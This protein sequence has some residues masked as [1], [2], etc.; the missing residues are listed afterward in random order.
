MKS[1]K[2]QIC[3]AVAL[4]LLGCGDKK[5]K[6]VSKPPVRVKTEIVSSQVC[7]SDQSYVG[8]VEENEATAVSFT[9]MGVIRKMYVD[10]GQYVR[11]GQLLA[12]MDNTTSES[13]LEITQVSTTQAHDMVDQAQATYDQAK[14][15]YERMKVM[16][17][18]GALPEIKW[19]EA[20]TSLRRA[21]T[22]LKTAQSGVT[23]AKATEKI[24][25][26][27][28]VD[29]RLYAPV[30]GI[31]GK[32]LLATGETALPSQAVV[33][34]LNI[35]NVKVKVPVPEME[36]RNI[37]TN[38]SSTISV[39]AAGVNVE[40]GSIEKGVQADALT[41]TYDVRVNVHN[42]GHALLPGMVANVRFG[43]YGDLSSLL[44]PITAVQKKG[45]GSLFVWTIADDN[46]AHRTAVSVGTTY[47]NRISVTGGITEGQRVVVEGYQ[48]LSEGT[49]VVYK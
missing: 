46:T 41:H 36:M 35:D 14:D 15:A 6:I 20:E 32:R 49:K 4:L 39:E 40:G 11:R 27:N 22:A 26:K 1:L 9:S 13:T 3:L 10:E 17:E 25:Q 30:S 44:L 21:E 23:S 29:N 47:G 37:S 42:S 28:V 31:I 8:I 18:A 12:E 48:K 24:A 43:K 7:N 38:T 45:D 33:S 34:I 19:I 16:Y 2:I 5:E